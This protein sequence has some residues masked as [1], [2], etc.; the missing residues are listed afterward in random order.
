MIKQQGW[1]LAGGRL[2]DFC[3]LEIHMLAHFGI[4]FALDHLLGHG[5]RILLGYIVEAGIR[6]RNHLYL[7][8]I[9]L[10]HIL[11]PEKMGATNVV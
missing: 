2:L 1:V 5:T 10:G 11:Y 6:G 9:C 8:G 3:F 7:D 4:I